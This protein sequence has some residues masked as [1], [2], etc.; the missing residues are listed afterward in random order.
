MKVHDS[1][2]YTTETNIFKHAHSVTDTNTADK[3][4]LHGA[5][6]PANDATA[7]GVVYHDTEK[8]M[9]LTVI[10]EGHIY[11][12]RLPEAP[13]K[14]AFDALRQINFYDGD[15]DLFEPETTTP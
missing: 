7:K 14:E 12:D 10:V 11:A 5:I 4:Y 2:K 1:I 15:S 13:T 3:N 8:G 6:F 9:P